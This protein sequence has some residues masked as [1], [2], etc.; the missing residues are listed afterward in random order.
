[1]NKKQAFRETIGYKPVFPVPFVN[2]FTPPLPD[3]LTQDI[4]QENIETMVN[5]AGEHVYH[6]EKHG[7]GYLI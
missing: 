7:K 3:A 6:L 1:M 4:L 2:G 5:L